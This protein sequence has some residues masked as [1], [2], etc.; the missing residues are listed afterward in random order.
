[1]KKLPIFASVLLLSFCGV[2]LAT[3]LQS[4]TKA[5]VVATIQNKTVTTIPLVTLEGKMINNTFTGYFDKNGQIQGQ[6]ENKPEG[7]PQTDQGQ[8]TTKADGTLCATWQ[9]WDQ[10]KPIC[11]SVFKLK[12]GLLFLNKDNKRLE[13]IILDQNIKT[14]NQLS[15]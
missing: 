9:H 15:S 14:G 10:S 7:G 4:L 11:V 6:M 12:N 3:S 8:W 2:A 5:Q 1:M 13:T